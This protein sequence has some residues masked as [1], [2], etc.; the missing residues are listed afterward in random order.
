MSRARLFSAL[1]VA[2][3]LTATACAPS[4]SREAT[5]PPAQN[6][7]ADT[8]KLVLE[9]QFDGTALNR[10]YWAPCYW[11]S[12]T[13][14]TGASNHELQL[15]TPDN[16]AVNNGMLSL[17]ARKQLAASDDGKPFLY[18]SGIVSGSSQN[19]TMVPFHYGY[20][21][22]RARVP[23]GSGLWSALWMLPANHQEKPEIDVFE[24]VGETPHLAYQSLHAASTQQPIRHV[25]HTPDDMTADWH[26]YGLDWEPSGL[27]WYIDGRQ[28]FSVTDAN[29]VPNVSMYLLIDLAVGGDFPTKVTPSTPFPSSLQVDY[30]RV[31]QRQ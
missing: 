20:V 28:T 29:V 25:E 12:T 17:T 31:W 9:D 23:V 8:W 16:V 19:K 24:I 15:Y 11:W 6:A 2:L 30:V 7:G 18:T 1:T 3:L 21:E 26:V 10:S 4:G 27:T 5:A 14:C 22:A 13:T